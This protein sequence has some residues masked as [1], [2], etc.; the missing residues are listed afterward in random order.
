MFWRHADE[1]CCSRSTRY[2]WPPMEW[3][4]DVTSPYRVSFPQESSQVKT[5]LYWSHHRSQAEA[6]GV[7]HLHRI[8]QQPLEKAQAPQEH[9]WKPGLLLLPTPEPK[10]P[11]TTG[12]RAF[13]PHT[14]PH[15][16]PRQIACCLVRELIFCRVSIQC[17]FSA[18]IQTLS[19]VPLITR[20]PRKRGKIYHL[21]PA[22]ASLIPPH[23]STQ[24]AL[25][26]L[27][28]HKICCCRTEGI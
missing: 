24:T 13:D 15:A 6:F 1:H 27:E 4:T 12:E 21:P 20:S 3:D 26:P 19:R 8:D 28:S 25:L 17:P 11:L 7:C 16:E 22:S 9:H 18:N 23:P 2:T 14:V 10:R 5:Q